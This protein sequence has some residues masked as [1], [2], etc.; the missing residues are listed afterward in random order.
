[1]TVWTLNLHK[2]N[3]KIDDVTTRSRKE[4]PITAFVYEFDVSDLAPGRSLARNSSKKQP[5]PQLPDTPLLRQARAT[6][7]YTKST[8]N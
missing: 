1:M 8:E 7:Q 5:T 4:D 3:T 2:R 6:V